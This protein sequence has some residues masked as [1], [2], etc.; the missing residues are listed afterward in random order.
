VATLLLPQETLIC[1]FPGSLRGEP[2]H[3]KMG[4]SQSLRRRMHADQGAGEKA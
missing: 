4:R 3:R 2:L 1:V